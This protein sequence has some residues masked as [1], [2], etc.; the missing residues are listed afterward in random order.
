MWLRGGV[1]R[2]LEAFGF[3]PECRRSHLL[4][5]VLLTEGVGRLSTES[6]KAGATSLLVSKDTL[7]SVEVTGLSRALRLQS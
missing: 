1:G 5:A 7:D 6:G 2:G 3:H 4:A